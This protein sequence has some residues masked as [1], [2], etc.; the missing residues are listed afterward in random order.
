MSIDTSANREQIEFWN[1]ES[2]QRWAER[3][4]VMA[5]MLAP[6]TEALLQHAEIDGCQRAL[7]IGCGGGSGTEQLARHLGPSARILGVDISEPMLAV[8][9]ARM[10][11]DP[12][13]AHAV[14][15]IH[16]DAT[17]YPFE[18]GSYDLL[19]SRF[20]VMFFEEPI[21]AFS[22]MASALAPSAHV[23][24]TCWQPP[25]ENPWVTL[26]L[27]AA[28]AHVPPPEKPDPRAPGPFAFADPDWVRE[29]LSGAG[30]ADIELTPA[31]FEMAHGAG[32]SVE[33]SVREMLTLGPVARLLA[34]V[35]EDTREK[36]YADATVLLGEHFSEG[37][38]RLPG[39]IW[40][41]TA[42]K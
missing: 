2:G 39:A 41:V 13:L 15:F 12:V 37:K 19:F 7:D 27:K 5:A 42:R 34:E 26:P 30:L 18:P 32:G 23:A 6:V 36:I 17:L 9:R 40:M 21:R 35:D 29:I 3:D 38:I 24:F 10:D 11:A 28:L 1:G 22:N 16:A 14:D 25:S 4:N 8:A 20:G 31:T 33:Q